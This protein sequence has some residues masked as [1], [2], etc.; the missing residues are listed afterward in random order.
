MEDFY[1]AG[2]LPALLGQLAKVPGALHLDRTIVTGGPFGEKITDAPIYNEDVIRTPDTALAAE[3]GVAVLRGN[4]APDGAVIKHI[5]AEPH[6]LKHTDPRSS[7]TPTPRC[8]S[9]STIR[10]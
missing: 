10:R 3:G 5:A 8:R 7:S 6:L 1:Y 9:G 4:L 2:G